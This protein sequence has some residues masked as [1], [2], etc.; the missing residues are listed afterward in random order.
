MNITYTRQKNNYWK[1]Q[2]RNKN[3]VIQI[4]KKFH[5]QDPTEAHQQFRS[6]QTLSQGILQKTIMHI[7]YIIKESIYLPHARHSSRKIQLRFNASNS[8]MANKHIKFYNSNI[9]QNKIYWY[10]T[11]CNHLHNMAAYLKLESTTGIRHL[12]FINIRVQTL[13]S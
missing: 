4:L 1:F 7:L 8:Q 6:M 3:I 13:K 11:S 5:H 2:V 10:S 9:N 12:K